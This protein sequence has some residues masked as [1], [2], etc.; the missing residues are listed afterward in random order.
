MA[1]WNALNL[2]AGQVAQM[3]HWIEVEGRTHQ[4]VGDQLGCV[5]QNVTKLCRKH[6]IQTRHS[7]PRSGAGHPEWLGGRIVDKD[8]YVLVYLPNH[9]RARRPRRI[10]VLEHVIVVEQALG[11]SLRVGEVVHHKNGNK[12]DKRPENLDVFACN[13]RH[14]RHELTGRTPRW[15]ED[16][17]ARIQQGIEKAARMNRGRSKRG[18]SV[19]L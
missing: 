1:K 16:G 10:Y 5:N 13:A 15:S 7:G 4:W 12:A 14:L 11:R 19:M 8:G 17:K 2:T 6:G 3:R 18:G 9:P